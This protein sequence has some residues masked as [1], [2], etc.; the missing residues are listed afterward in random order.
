MAAL[1]STQLEDL[2][3][4]KARLKH[5]EGCVGKVHIAEKDLPLLD[6]TI[7][8]AQCSS[9]FEE[10]VVAVREGNLFGTL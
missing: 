6:A 3:K 2:E 4:K 7:Y 8:S 5:K 10:V 1:T 9:C